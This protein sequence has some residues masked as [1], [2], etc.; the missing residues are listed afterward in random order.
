M[1]DVNKLQ[2]LLN[3]TDAADGKAVALIFGEG[4]AEASI[5]GLLESLSEDESFARIFNEISEKIPRDIFFQNI[6]K[7]LQKINPEE[8]EKVLPRIVRWD[9]YETSLFLCHL[10][11]SLTNDS[12]R[13]LVLKR[14]TRM[15]TL[16]PVKGEI[17]D[18]YLENNDFLTEIL[19]FLRHPSP[20]IRE[21]GLSLLSSTGSAKAAETFLDFF[22]TEHK[23]EVKLKWFKFLGRF[24]PQTILDLINRI[25]DDLPPDLL[26]ELAGFLKGF[27]RERP[28]FYLEFLRSFK[29]RREIFKKIST[30]LSGIVDLSCLPLL[31]DSV[32]SSDSGEGKV[33]FP[34][35]ENLVNYHLEKEKLNWEH[36]NLRKHKHEIERL[37]KSENQQ[38]RHGTLAM[39]LKFKA[40]GLTGVM[41]FYHD[42]SN[43]DKIYLE[44]LFKNT[45]PTVMLPII[46]RTVTSGNQKTLLS[47]LK[48][49]KNIGEQDY[50][51]FV[52]KVIALDDPE[53]RP[54]ALKTAEDLG[55]TPKYQIY[56]RDEKEDLRYWACFLL[57]NFPK[58]ENLKIL[59]EK[60]VDPSVKVRQVA[61]STMLCYAG[62]PETLSILEEAFDDPDETV[63]EKAIEVLGKIGTDSAFLVLQKNLDLKPFSPRLKEKVATLLYVT[64]KKE[65]V[66]TVKIPEEAK[67]IPVKNPDRLG[68][69]MLDNLRVKLKDLNPEVR[70][71]AAQILVTY[72]DRDDPAILPLLHDAAVDPDKRIRALIAQALGKSGDRT[73]YRVLL[74]LLNDPN[75]RVR[76]NV[77]QSLEKFDRKDEVIALLVPF[78][79]D[80]N[81]RVRANV[82]VALWRLQYKNIWGTLKALLDHK[83]DRHVASALY[84]IREISFKGPY[85]FMKQYFVSTSPIVKFNLLLTIGKL[86]IRDQFIPEIQSLTRD[87]EP[88][89]REAARELLEK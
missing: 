53:V 62:F 58:R 71:Q 5:Y 65:L 50:L 18:Y 48:I 19:I 20:D 68:K 14:I 13:N 70:F 77:V 16:P 85:I 4:G 23:H 51:P 35:L 78:L 59:S 24:N 27:S 26:E 11:K 22:R 49:I 21:R 45:S 67:E 10:Y 6:S 61:V 41:D 55:M 79:D 17:T 82:I 63:Q 66:E 60:L 89:V 46:Q 3:S 80:S 72:T 64:E 34:A 39:L 84:A 33:F 40:E 28:R 75:D 86:G 29:G 9:D 12:K 31:V 44:G 73:S 47:M 25:I 32:L 7:P 37:L 52:I 57:K 42:T 54:A 2:E 36:G 43:T 83:D 30:A 69:K 1:N 15:R 87:S 76:A 8:F 74:K 88:R 81:N 56:C 38:I